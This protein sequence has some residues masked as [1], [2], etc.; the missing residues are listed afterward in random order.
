MPP[1]HCVSQG[2]GDDK[3][4][5]RSHRKEP[6]IKNVGHL[7]PWASPQASLHNHG[8]KVNWGLAYEREATTRHQSLLLILLTRPEG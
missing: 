7:F 2:Y 6:D 3:G 4:I 5:R 1:M 8:G